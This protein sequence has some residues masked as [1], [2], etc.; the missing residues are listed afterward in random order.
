MR[1]STPHEVPIQEQWAGEV[2]Y[3]LEMVATLPALYADQCLPGPARHA[4]MDSFFLNL[5]ALIEFA[6]RKQDNRDIHRSDFLTGEA[7]GAVPADTAQKL[8]EAWEL[9]S[10]QIAHLS[11]KRVVG[12]TGEFEPVTADDMR[13]LAEAVFGA[14]DS[15]RAALRS[16]GSEYADRFT[17]VLETARAIAA[18]G[19]LR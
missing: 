3:A 5:R 12:T 13:R 6:A 16:E 15:F 17:T 1:P 4:C 11:K 8:N 10:Q 9:A 2:Q 7:S 14:F 19:Q 18:Q